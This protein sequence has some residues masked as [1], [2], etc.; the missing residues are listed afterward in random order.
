MITC[1]IVLYKTKEIIGI[2][3]FDDTNILIDKDIN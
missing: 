3:K 1:Q 2:E